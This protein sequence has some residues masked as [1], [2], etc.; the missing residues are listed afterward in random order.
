MLDPCLPPAKINA[1]D[2]RIRPRALRA[3][4][5][6]YNEDL[7]SFVLYHMVLWLSISLAQSRLMTSSDREQ[8][9]LVRG[10]RTLIWLDQLQNHRAACLLG[11]WLETSLQ[12][13]EALVEF[14]Q[15]I[16]NTSERPGHYRDLAKSSKERVNDGTVMY[17]VWMEAPRL[18]YSAD[19]G[20]SPTQRLFTCMN[21]P[22]CLSASVQVLVFC[23][24]R[25]TRLVPGG[26]HLDQAGCRVRL[27]LSLRARSPFPLYIDDD[28]PIFTQ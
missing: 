21:I 11:C 7:G 15:A 8:R 22:S 13:L 6:V 27:A 25:P 20:L 12:I 28:M 17:M 24:C 26:L 2:S 9:L 3:G 23:L 18:V 5:T 16:C 4:R 19:P 1:A 10:T 14:N